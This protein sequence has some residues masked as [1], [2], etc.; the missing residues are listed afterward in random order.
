ME[1][2]RMMLAPYLYFGPVE[3]TQQV[4]CHLMR[5]NNY[6]LG[7]LFQRNESFYVYLQTVPWVFIVLYNH[8]GK[9]LQK[10]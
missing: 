7:Y 1:K 8:K 4:N 3:L 10:L 2:T 6:G 9:K 5:P